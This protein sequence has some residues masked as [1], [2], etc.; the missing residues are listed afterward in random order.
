MVAKDK[1]TFFKKNR[2]EEIG[3]LKAKLIF[4]F[5]LE[6][7]APEFYNQVSVIPVNI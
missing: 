1:D 7:M 4:D 6:K 3:D 5:I 2:G